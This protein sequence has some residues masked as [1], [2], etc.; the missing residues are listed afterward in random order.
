M[1]KRQIVTR[2]EKTSATS[3]QVMGREVPAGESEWIVGQPV[4]KKWDTEKC[5][6][7]RVE[8]RRNDSEGNMAQGPL[9][10]SQ[11]SLS[12]NRAWFFRWLCFGRSVC[13][14]GRRVVADRDAVEVNAPSPFY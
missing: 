4:I 11:Y 12:P 3:S 5:R 9:A 14:L 8:N 7:W 1:A 13:I 2:T 10:T 6:L